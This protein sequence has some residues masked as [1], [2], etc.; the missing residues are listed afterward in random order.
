M[1][2]ILAVHCYFIHACRPVLRCCYS[3]LNS[4][5]LCVFPVCWT[6][7][8]CQQVCFKVKYCLCT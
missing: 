1:P 7:P 6:Q 5:G 8:A 4:V 3:V 2:A